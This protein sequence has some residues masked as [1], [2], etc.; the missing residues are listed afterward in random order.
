MGQTTIATFFGD[1]EFPVEFEDGQR[2]L[3]W[4]HDDL[5]IPNPVSPMYADIGG[6]WLKCDYMFRRFGTPFASD[7]IS[8][9]I[10]GYVYTAAIPAEPGLSAETSEYGARYTPRTPIDESYPAEIGGYLGWTLPYYAENFL[11]WWR[12]RLVPEMTRNFERFDGYDYDGASLVEL[13]VLLEDAIDMHDRHW[14]IHWVLNFAQFS[15]TMGLNAVIA[16]AKGEGDHSALMGRLQSST[17]NRN[18]DSIEELW[19]IK[20]NIKADP[21][22]AVAAAFRKPTAADVV[23][24]LESTDAGRAF[25]AEDIEGYSKEFGYKSMYAHEFSFKTWRENPAPIIEGVR[26][27]LEADYDYPAEIAAVAEDLEAAKAEVLAGV[28]DGEVKDRLV[29][30]LDL[31]LRMNPLT[32][33]HHFYI[34][35]GTNARVRLVLVAIGRKLVEQGR[36]G[37]PEDVMYLRYNELRV[38]MAGSNSFDA[39]DLVGDRRD[40]RETAYELRPR[41]WVGTA[42]EEN[43]AFPYLSLWAFPEKLHRKPSTTEGEVHGLAAS[44][45]VVEGT[46][47]VVLS[48]EQFQEVQADEIIVCRMTS[49]AWVVLFTKIGGLV[50]DAGGMASHPAVVSRE[51][52]IPAVVGTSDATRRIK[53]GDRV[54]VNGATGVV[55]VL[56]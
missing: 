17:T 50:T 56:T 51:F 42:T 49:P 36:L 4:V 9:I 13:A 19:K 15:S 8:K 1:D 35:Q 20:E 52:G 12:E 46:A 6:W 44:V 43:V 5:H 28:A 26:G 2:E 30:A 25:L 21:D 23:R 16:E 14:S 33:D 38:L 41:D 29:Q 53:T 18:W 3:L 37:D 7:W 11:H 22:G 54:R 32:P 47:R 45:G 31:S 27:Y 48:P 39:E 34:D 24:E 10:N 55:Q 40:E